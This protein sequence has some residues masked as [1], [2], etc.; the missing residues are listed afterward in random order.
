MN[1]ELK[2]QVADTVS[3]FGFAEFDKPNTD[4]IEACLLIAECLGLTMR[5]CSYKV[6]SR[7]GN[8]YERCIRLEARKTL[9]RETGQAYV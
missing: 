6:C 1:E 9:A 7:Y 4:D 3:R 2:A 5:I 8:Y